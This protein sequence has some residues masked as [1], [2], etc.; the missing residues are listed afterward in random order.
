MTPGCNELMKL[1][2]N[3]TKLKSGEQLGKEIKGG[4]REIS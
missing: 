3:L 1:P 2:S 4:S